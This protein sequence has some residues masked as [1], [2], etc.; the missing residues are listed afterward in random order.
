MTGGRIARVLIA[1][2]LVGGAI[3]A[4]RSMPELTCATVRE[5]GDRPGSVWLGLGLATL[6]IVLCFPRQ[7]M[8]VACGL[9]FG[10]VIGGLIAQ[11]AATIGACV[12][13]V[14]AR[15]LA[16]DWVTKM[17]LKYRWFQGFGETL[18]SSGTSFSFFLRLN[19]I[20][21]FS[22]FSYACGLIPLRFVPFAVGTFLG[23]LP[24]TVALAY[25]AEVVGCALLDKNTDVPNEAKIWLGAA[26]VVA[27]ALSL[28]PVAIAA[29][30]RKR[31]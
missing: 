1:L 23:A 22:I 16:R 5:Y 26:W 28:L 12:A 27:V 13:F 14:I 8:I 3:F 17:L 4:I 15:Y 20:L 29:Y 19:P 31:R 25:A 21:H 18:G 9:T 30:K 24:A 7:I 2:F 11:A 10:A 6:S